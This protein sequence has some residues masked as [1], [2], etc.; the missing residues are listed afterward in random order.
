[1]PSTGSI[2]VGGNTQIPV[3]GTGSVHLQVTDS[4]GN[5][6]ILTLDRVLYAPRLKFNLFSV[7]AGV[8]NGLRFTFNRKVCSIQ[9]DQRFNLK[10]KLADHADLYQFHVTPPKPQQAHVA[11]SGKLSQLTLLH[12]RL[13]HPNIRVLQALHKNSAIQGVNPT[14]IDPNVTLF[15]PSCTFAKSHR[16]PFYSN[17]VVEVRAGPPLSWW[18]RTPDEQQPTWSA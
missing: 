11:A 3:E 10:A 1:M 2:T 15:C 12:K 13:G 18:Q 17:R 8:K 9:T 4:K 7:A 14:W 5:R 6:R 16:D